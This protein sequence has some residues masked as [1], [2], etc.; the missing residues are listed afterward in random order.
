[1]LW[2]RS[3]A[4]SEVFWSP[5]NTRNWTGFVQR[6]EVNL[7]RLS[8]KDIN[9]STSFYDAIIEPLK[10]EQGNLLIQMDTEIEGIEIYYTFDNTLPDHHSLLYK[11]GEKLTLP[12]DADTFR[13]ITY[14]YG[15]PV[16]RMIAVSLA[17]LA[18][19]IP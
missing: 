11:R 4:L 17:D 15:K 2:P 8:Q 10:D 12:V 16:G 3:F 6:T 14:R 5:K 1:M 19:R 18:K 7:Q 13:V 9:F